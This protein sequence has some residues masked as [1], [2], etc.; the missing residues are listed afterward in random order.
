[1][2]PIDDWK[3]MEL[4]IFQPKLCF[5]L[6]RVLP[7]SALRSVHLEFATYW[8][9]IAKLVLAHDLKGLLSRGASTKISE[10]LVEIEFLDEPDADCAKFTGTWAEFQSFVLEQIESHTRS[11]SY[12]EHVITMSSAK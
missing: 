11:A 8:V 7:A 10:N 5:S 2:A 1:M 12:Y 3:P 4:P 6:L 9:D